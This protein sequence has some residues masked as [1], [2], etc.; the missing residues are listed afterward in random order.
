MDTVMGTFFAF[1][2]FFGVL[3]VAAWALYEISPFAR[4]ADQFRDLRT[5]IRRGTSP[6]L[7]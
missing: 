2:F 3:A 1:A 5:G 7:D 4:H 6:R